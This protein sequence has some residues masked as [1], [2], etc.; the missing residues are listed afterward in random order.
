MSD[1]RRKKKAGA[2]LSQDDRTAQGLEL[3]PAEEQ[4]LARQVNVLCVC[5]QVM[6]VVC[7]WAW[8]LIVTCAHWMHVVSFTH[9]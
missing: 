4:L 3:T 8:V 9:L 6:A 7:A 1:A 2:G 5:A